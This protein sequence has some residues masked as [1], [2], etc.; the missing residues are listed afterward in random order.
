MAPTETILGIDLGANSLGWALIEAPKGNPCRIVDAGV[1]VFEAG[2]N[3]RETGEKASLNIERRNARSRRRLI[4]RRARRMRKLLHILQQSNLLP[5][6]ELHGHLRKGEGSPMA[7]FFLDPDNE[8][9]QLRAKALSHKISPYQI[10]RCLYH[11]ARRRGFEFNRKTPKKDNEDE[12]KL[13]KETGQLENEWIAKGARTLGEYLASLDPHDR[14]RRGIKT[15]RRWYK[16]EFE[17]IWENQKKYHPELLKEDLKNKIF[18]AIFNQRPLKSQNKYIG[19]CQLETDNPQYIPKRAAWATLLAQR[20]RMLQDVNNSRIIDP[21]NQERPLNPEE[22]E[23]L[24]SILEKKSMLKFTDTRNKILKLPKGSKFNYE[25]GNRK[26][27]LGNKTAEKMISIFGEQWDKMSA[28]EKDQAVEDVIS[29]QC[30]KALNKRGENFWKLTGDN[31]EK[32]VSFSPEAGYCNISKRALKKLIPLL[33]Q[34]LSYSEAVKKVYPEKANGTILDKIPP[35]ENL[36]NPIVQ[37]SLSELR[38]VVNCL[39]KKHGKPGRIRIELARELKKN[40]EERIRII[41]QMDENEKDRKRARE[42]LEEITEFENPTNFMIQKYLLWEECKGVCPYTGKPIPLTNLFS[43]SSEFDIDHI[44]PF[45]RSLNDSFLN[46]TLCHNEYNRTIKRNQTPWET[47]G[48][49]AEAGDPKKKKEWEDILERVK[50]FESKRI[51]SWRDYNTGEIKTTTKKSFEKLKRFQLKKVD[52]EEVFLSDFTSKQLND[53]RYAS[54]K[55]REVLAKLYGIEGF[56]KVQVVTGQITAYLRRAWDLNYLLDEENTKTRSDHRHHAIDAICVALTEQR[57][58]H[59]LHIA[60]K[61][62]VLRKRAGSFSRM[63]DPWPDFQENIKSMI[64]SIIVSHKVSNKVSGKLHE[65]THYG[66]IRSPYHYER[67]DGKYYTVIRKKLSELEG[68]SES[69]AHQ[70][71]DSIV[72][73]AVRE[74][75]IE[76]LQELMKKNKIDSFRNAIKLFSEEENHPVFFTRDGRRVPIHKTRIKV[77]CNPSKIAGGDHER[78]VKTGNNHHLAVYEIKDKKGNIKW[79]SEIV[80]LFEA[81][82]RK[83]FKEPIIKQVDENGNPL[84]F[85][86]SINEAVEIDWNGKREI[87]IVQNLSDRDYRFY[88][89]E[90]ARLSG[91]K[92]VLRVR[93]DNKLLHSRCRKLYISPIGEIRRAENGASS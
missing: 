5:A 46:K 18:K 60:A 3:L 79:R 24:I 48:A 65:E 83:K 11:I 35:I 75:I 14:R 16:E 15:L 87:A 59:Q 38:R 40:T 82:R 34:G 10:G 12:G 55:A 25:N 29:I 56:K 58:V 9:Y 64:Q 4:E 41:K 51:V 33:E 73:K 27:F 7:D 72:D 68:N 47:C 19:R 1:R 17:K 78:W 63:E 80:T 66:K 21:S 43:D 44:I 93:G 85:S 92:D 13:E 8:P 49:A 2:V 90:D 84:V 45:T 26:S 50:N 23:K 91:K 71:I 6:G 74:K 31:L 54:R 42:R 69:A 61:Y 77:Q 32:F 76:K 86:L 22:R 67:K 28:L 36:R 52:D 57:I 37:R 39:I 30:K 53:T 89:P 81:M 88:R 20:F 70:N 62:G